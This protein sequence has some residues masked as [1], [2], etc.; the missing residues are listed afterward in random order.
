MSKLQLPALNSLRFFEA[1]AR[2]QSI[3]QAGDELHV[4]PTAVGRHI[5]GLE[6]QLGRALFERHHRKIVLNDDGKILLRAVTTSFSHIQRAIAQLSKNELPEA[7]VISVD[8]DFAALWLVPR[9]ADVVG[10]VYGR[11]LRDCDRLRRASD[12]HLGPRDV[13]SLAHHERTKRGVDCRHIVCSDDTPTH[14]VGCYLLSITIQ[15]CLHNGGVSTNEESSGLVDRGT[16]SWNRR[17]IVRTRC[18][19]L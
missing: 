13:R 2:H 14:A 17:P 16:N 12:R 9:L 7:L 6:R 1:V 4:T 11:Y 8:P 15:S 19:I 18:A 5:Q 3:K 10:L